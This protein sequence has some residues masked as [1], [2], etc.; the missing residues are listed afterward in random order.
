MSKCKYYFFY[1]PRF[2][3]PVLIKSNACLFVRIRPS[4]NIF[5]G[6]NLATTFAIKTH[7]TQK[8]FNQ[9]HA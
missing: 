9:G 5:S 8:I 3:M 6:M 7:A 4:N 1:Q 2:F